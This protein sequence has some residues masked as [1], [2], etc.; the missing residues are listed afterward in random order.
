MPIS[1]S[2]HVT[3]VPFLAGWEYGSL[4]PDLRKAFEVALHGGTALALLLSLREELRADLAAA[5]PRLAGLILCSF[6][7]AAAVGFVLEGPIERR[8]GTPGSIAVGMI[9][10]GGVLAWADRAPQERIEA[11]GGYDDGL[12]LGAA[13]ACALIPGVSRNGATLTAARLRRFRRIDANRLSWHVALP[14]IGAATGLKFLRLVR[15][16]LPPGTAVPFAVGAGASFGSTLLS[17][18]VLGQVGRDR[19]LAPYGIYRI[20]L[21][22]AVLRRLWYERR[23]DRPMTDN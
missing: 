14:I 2:G 18:W 12:W 8:L 21:G 6:V 5:S 17:T 11:E 16:G 23:A 3:V 1:S 13:Q 7:P 19:S 20:A 9:V 10:G 4:Q 15:G 22:S